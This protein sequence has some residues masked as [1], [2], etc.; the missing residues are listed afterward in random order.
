MGKGD[1]VQLLRLLYIGYI[2]E[3]PEVK[4]ILMRA[5]ENTFGFAVHKLR[6]GPEYLGGVHGKGAVDINGDFRN[7]VLIEKLVQQIDEKLG[8]SHGKRGD[9]YL[10]ACFCCFAYNRGKFLLHICKLVMVAVA[11]RGFNNECVHI[12]YDIRIADDWDI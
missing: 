12:A 8:A 1:M 2:G 9:D 7:A 5:Q 3:S 10:S 6:M 4:R 11:I